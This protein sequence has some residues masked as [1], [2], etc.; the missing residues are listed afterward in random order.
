[1]KIIGDLTVLKISYRKFHDFQNLI[2]AQLS[3]TKTVSTFLEGNKAL[4]ASHISQSKYR[5]FDPKRASY[6]RK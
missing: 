2:S 6:I 4:V 1:M 5:W 3:S